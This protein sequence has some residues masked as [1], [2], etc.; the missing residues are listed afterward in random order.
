VQHETVSCFVVGEPRQ[1]NQ[2]PSQVTPA[3][4]KLIVALKKNFPLIPV[5]REDERFTS[6]IAQRSLLDSGL[7]KKDRQKKELV[8]LASAV[9]IL[10]S[11]MERKARTGLGR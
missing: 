6:L 8:D 4:E 3:I 1:M 9:L 7:K 2:K 10:Q 5:D 11:Y